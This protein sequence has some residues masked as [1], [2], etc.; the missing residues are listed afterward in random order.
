MQSLRGISIVVGCLLHANG[1]EV[2]MPNIEAMHVAKVKSE[3]FQHLILFT[4]SLSSAG[5]QLFSVSHHLKR[6]FESRN[7]FI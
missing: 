4:Y 5:G 2:Q 1:T 6:S 3:A 7:A